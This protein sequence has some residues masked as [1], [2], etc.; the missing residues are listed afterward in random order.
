MRNPSFSRRRYFIRRTYP[1]NIGDHIDIW[2]NYQVIDGTGNYSLPRDYWR[3]KVHI[4]DP[5]TDTQR[6]FT[7]RKESG[8]RVA[9]L[10]YWYA[11]LRCRIFDVG[12]SLGKRYLTL[13]PTI[14]WQNLCFFSESMPDNIRWGD[15]TDTSRLWG[16]WWRLV[17]Y[18]KKETC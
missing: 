4:R 3:D 7:Y 17:L 13:P 10:L 12:K 6:R 14:L 8:C 9:W 2:T 1:P 15:K 11:Q 5:G 16:F 18:Q